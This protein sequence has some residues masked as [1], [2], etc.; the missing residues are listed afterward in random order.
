MKWI[1]YVFL[2]NFFVA[3]AVADNPGLAGVP[4][5]VIRQNRVIDASAQA[6]A[7]GVSPGLTRRHAVQNCPEV[8]F[9]EF[10]AHRYE[11]RTAELAG[12]CSSLSPRVETGGANKALDGNEAFID[13]SGNRPPALQVLAGLV[14]GLVPRLGSF[15]TIGL[16]P[17]HLLAKAAALTWLSPVLSP[18]AG[19]PPAE[20]GRSPALP[21][22]TAKAYAKFRLGLVKP[23]TARQFASRLPVEMMWPLETA[24]IERLKSLGL[25]LCSEVSAV[26]LTMLRRQFGSLAPVLLDYSRGTDQTNI[27]VFRPPDRIIYHASCEGADRLRL[28]EILK[29]AAV[30]ISGVLQERGQ[31]CRALTLTVFWTGRPPEIKTASFTREK[32]EVRSI[33]DSC[34]NLLAAVGTAGIT[35]AAAEIS[36]AAGRLTTSHY[37]QMALF[38]DLRTFTGRAAGLPGQTADLTRQAASMT[39]RVAGLPGQAAGATGRVA[40]TTG[41]TAGLTGRDTGSAGRD[42][43]RDGGRRKRLARVCENLAVKYT[44]GVVTTGSTLPVT[45][46]EQM[47]MFVDPLRNRV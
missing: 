12:Q 30:Y 26:P 15:A 16:A 3:A 6:V 2:H 29:Q 19:H 39:G 4:L 42:T 47:L 13:L 10:K 14:E 41:Q 24:V 36:L 1:A 38:E 33:Y 44:P 5:A 40:V 46:R 37:R 23:E 27:P 34:L 17:C 11:E 22:L 21:G 20:Q 28:A 9:V 25:G 45:R 8:K 31:S 43:G 35:G 7:G 32:H 18:P